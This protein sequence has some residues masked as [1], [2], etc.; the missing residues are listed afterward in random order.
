MSDRKK[1]R[2]N[3]KFLV[4]SRVA[5]HKTE[6]AEQVSRESGPCSLGM[7]SLKSLWHIEWGS[8]EAAQDNYETPGKT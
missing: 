6:E 4:G 5:D 3:P 7:L 1:C 2:M 8:H